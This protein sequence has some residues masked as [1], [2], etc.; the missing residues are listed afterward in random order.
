MTVSIPPV[1]FPAARTVR[2]ITGRLV[3][4]GLVLTMSGP[5]SPGSQPAPPQWSGDRSGPWLRYAAAGLCV[6]AA[7][8]AAVSFSAFGRMVDATRHLPVIA[9]RLELSGAGPQP[10][11]RSG[12]WRLAYAGPGLSPVLIDRCTG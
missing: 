8:A 2:D 10:D 7:A 4:S 11:R 1:P 3:T 12:P 9:V 5:A 6:L